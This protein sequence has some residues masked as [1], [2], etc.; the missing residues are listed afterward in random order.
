MFS[1]VLNYTTSDNST[2]VGGGLSTTAASMSATPTNGGSV[3]AAPTTSDASAAVPTASD[4]SA[5]APTA[6]DA[7]TAP[8]ASPAGSSGTPFPA[9]QGSH[10]SCVSPSFSVIASILL[11][12]AILD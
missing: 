11:L 2:G 4:T 9:P 8:S 6:S 5:A 1:L 7:S 12:A 10:A 3:I